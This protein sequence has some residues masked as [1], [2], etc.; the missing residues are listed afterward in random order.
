MSEGGI[1]CVELP[2]P[3]TQEILRRDFPR[4]YEEVFWANVTLR[5]LIQEPDRVVVVLLPV[6]GDM[7]GVY[8]YRTDELLLREEN[9]QIVIYL[10]WSQDIIFDTEDYVQP[11]KTVRSDE[12]QDGARIM[13]QQT[14]MSPDWIE[15]FL[16]SGYITPEEFY[17]NRNSLPLVKRLPQVAVRRW[18]ELADGQS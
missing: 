17:L 16:N 8:G 1:W 13:W 14:T 6:L 2:S 7:A 4:R 18:Y 9:G 15:G 11:V 3:R 10:D 12:L 5:K